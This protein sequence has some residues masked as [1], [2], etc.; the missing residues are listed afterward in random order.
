MQNSTKIGYGP[1]THGYSSAVIYLWWLVPPWNLDKFIK[2]KFYSHTIYVLEYFA[3]WLNADMS[4]D[5]GYFCRNMTLVETGILQ[6]FSLDF[7]LSKHTTYLALKGDLWGVCIEQSGGNWSRNFKS[8][9]YYSQCSHL[10]VAAFCEVP[11]QLS[12]TTAVRTRRL[13]RLKMPCA[14]WHPQTNI[15][16]CWVTKQ[17][18]ENE[19]WVD[20]YSQFR[21]N[22]FEPIHWPGEDDFN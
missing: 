12:V 20:F 2:C 10:I 7:K 13:P 9:P 18:T 21:A 5:V 22:G 3:L 6:S 11:Y 15:N 14:W 4:R 1:E 19:K 16:D 17:I 8:A